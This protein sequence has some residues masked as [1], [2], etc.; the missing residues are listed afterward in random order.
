MSRLLSIR[1]LQG[2]PSIQSFKMD[3]VR[4]ATVETLYSS[5]RLSIAS[6]RM[7]TVNL[8]KRHSRHTDDDSLF[9]V[10]SPTVFVHRKEI[11]EKTADSGSR[12]SSNTYKCRNTSGWSTR[13]STNLV[14]R[15]NAVQ[16]IDG[17]GTSKERVFASNGF[18]PL[19]Q[20]ELGLTVLDKV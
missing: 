18:R 5:L 13:S 14:E 4:K 6:A 10:S 8:A 11:Y 19:I 3:F 2:I 16:S 15:A 1:Q 17:L 7:R 12:C 20:N 9:P